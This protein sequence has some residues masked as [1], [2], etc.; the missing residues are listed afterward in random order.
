MSQKSALILGASGE[1]GKELLAKL[2]AS[3][4]F[5]KIVSI[6]RK[7]IELPD[8]EDYKKVEQKIVDFDDLNQY[9]ADFSGVDAA[10]CC[11]GTT[12]GKA[13]K[14]GFIKV[15]H[16][17]VLSA[18]QIVKTGGCEE[19]HLLTSKG[20]NP[21]GWFL[22]PST[23][24]KVEEAVKNVGFSK[25]GIYR[26]GLLMCDRQEKRAGEGLIR[27]VAGVTDARHG[28]SIPTS[29]VAAAM[30]SNCLSPSAEAVKIFE[31]SDLVQLG[32]E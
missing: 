31:H 32:I 19:F 27:W 20:S 7:E 14:E 21:N 26:P 22:Y 5:S 2:A 12:R 13:G 28:W 4:T 3:P 18:A 15:D 16:D 1:T 30:V 8:K 6:G 9:A 10:F 29:M 24:G 25:L 17:Y 11:L 23:K